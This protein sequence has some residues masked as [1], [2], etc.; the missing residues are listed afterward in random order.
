MGVI[1]MGTKIL[2]LLLFVSSLAFSQTKITNQSNAEKIKISELKNFKKD[3]SIS[4]FTNKTSLGEMLTEVDAVWKNSSLTKKQ[5][6]SLRK[7][8]FAIYYILRKLE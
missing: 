6:G 1:I 5:E 4:Y 8:Y 2:F 3:S 7:L